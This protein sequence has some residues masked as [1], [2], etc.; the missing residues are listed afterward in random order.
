MTTIDFY[1]N[2]KWSQTLKYIADSGQI[3]ESVLPYFDSKLVS[4]DE[5]N[6]I[7]TVPAFINYA[8]MSDHIDLIESCLEE[9]FHKNLSVKLMQQEDYISS[10]AAAEKDYESDF[11]PRKIDPNQTFAN[12][13]VGRS[14]HRPRSLP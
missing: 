10:S 8:I 7:I 12:F 11:L 14:T 13:V 4:L 6:A 9:V 2:D 5:D 1:L 3:A